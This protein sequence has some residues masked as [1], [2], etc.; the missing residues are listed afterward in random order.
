M[1]HRYRCHFRK[2]QTTLG[3]FWQNNQTLLRTPSARWSVLPL[4][5]LDN[6][7]SYDDKISGF[8]HG[9]G[10]ELRP[11]KGARWMCL[12]PCTSCPTQPGENRDFCFKYFHFHW[13]FTFFQL[14]L[15]PNF[16][17]NL[18]VHFHFFSLDFPFLP[19][20]WGIPGEPEQHPPPRCSPSPP[21]RPPLLH[22]LHR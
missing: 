5:Q 12:L 16:H 15:S 20:D 10:D 11:I 17:F 4:W 9:R 22:S 6:N 8:V 13:T 1:M 2:W 7:D 21:A 14:L 18:V 19:G 3:P